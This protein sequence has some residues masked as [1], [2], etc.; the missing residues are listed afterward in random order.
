M[1]EGFWRR[2]LN[3]V[4]GVENF[5]SMS[6]FSFITENIMI[7]FPCILSLIARGEVDRIPCNMGRGGKDGQSLAS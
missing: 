4:V 7:N 2:V 1:A 3:V 6:P 5:P